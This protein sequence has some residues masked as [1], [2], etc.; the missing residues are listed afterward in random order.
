MTLHSPYIFEPRA[1]DSATEF[2][3]GADFKTGHHSAP[4]SIYCLFGKR[5]LDVFLVLLAAPVVIVVVMLLAVFVSCNGGK[6]FYFQKR[7]GQNGSIYTMWKLRTMVA[8]ADERLETYLAQTPAARREWDST[9]KLKSDPRIT[10]FGQF[11]R[12][13][14]LDEL[15]QLWNVLTGD[16]S[17][18]GP[19]P[20]MPCQQEIYPGKEYYAL[21][22]GITG[23]W[24]V[25]SRNESTF[26]DRARFDTHYSRNVSLKTDLQLLVATVKVVVRA[27]GH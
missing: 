6:P 15:P 12:K 22:P 19:R 11:L 13:S 8:D 1:R 10:A 9:Q 7:I 23:P 16:M 5:T 27:T 21:R 26:V 18:V 20:M 14:S 2:N 3:R 25:S 17:L 24:Q 4:Q